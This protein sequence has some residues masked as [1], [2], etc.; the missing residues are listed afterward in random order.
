MEHEVGNIL[1]DTGRTVEFRSWDEA[2]EGVF[3]LI[4][5]VRFSGNCGVVPWPHDSATDGPLGF[6]YVSDGAV[7]PFSQISC[8]KIAGS[9]GPAV[10]RMEP[11][12][13]ETLFGRAMGRVV[14]HELIHMISGSA[15]HSHEGIARS[16]FSRSDLTSERLGL[17]PTDLARVTAKERR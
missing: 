5:V 1:R 16:A 15:I 17:S 8:E 9:L 14:A 12:Q 2:T 11:S 7:L 13:A 10:P 3:D 4:A 6:T